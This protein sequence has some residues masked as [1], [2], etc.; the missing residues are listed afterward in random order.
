MSATAINGA[1]WAA[2]TPLKKTLLLDLNAV[3]W[4]AE[5]AEGLTVVDGFTL[6]L[7]NDNDFGLK[8][9][10]FT[11]AGAEVAGADPT[12]CSVDATGAIVTSSASGCNSSNTMRVARGDDRERPARLW[13]IKFNKALTSY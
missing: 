10:V 8:T 3:G 9:R 7:A 12:A 1:S 13:L 4:L 6:A 2:V 5:K 11:A